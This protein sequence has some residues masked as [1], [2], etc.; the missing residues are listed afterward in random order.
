MRIES[1]TLIEVKHDL[2]ERFEPFNVLSNAHT[3]LKPETT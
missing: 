3:N 2:K 1:R